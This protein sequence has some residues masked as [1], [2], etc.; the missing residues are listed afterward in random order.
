[1]LS[2]AHAVLGLIT[3]TYLVHY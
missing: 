2:F 1:L 3:R